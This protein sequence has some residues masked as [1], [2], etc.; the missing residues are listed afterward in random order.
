MSFVPQIKYHF[1]IHWI[2]AALCAGDIDVLMKISGYTNFRQIFTN[3]PTLD[4]CES[5]DSVC[6]DECGLRNK[7]LESWLEIN[8]AK[9]IHDLQKEVDDYP[10]MH[11]VA[12]NVYINA[13]L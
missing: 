6:T 3:A 1:I 9:V 11:A 10:C 12:V 13:S 7:N 4:S 8:Y 2:D 5:A